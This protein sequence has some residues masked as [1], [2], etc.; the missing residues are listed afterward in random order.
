MVVGNFGNGRP[1]SGTSSTARYRCFTTPSPA[2]TPGAFRRDQRADRSQAPGM[3]KTRK[4]VRSVADLP[5]LL[6]ATYRNRVR[7]LSPG[8][9]NQGVKHLP[10]SRNICFRGTGHSFHGSGSR[11]LLTKENTSL[12][13]GHAEPPIGIEPM[14]YALREARSAAFMP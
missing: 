9:Q 10:G 12:S 14:T 4:P 13:C 3:C 6:S 2:S 11:S 8:N 7:T 5:E 1:S